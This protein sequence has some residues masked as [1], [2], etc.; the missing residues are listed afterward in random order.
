MNK[1]DFINELQSRINYTQE[2]CI[3]VNDVLE[4]HYVFRKKNKAKITEDLK[5]KLSISEEQ[6]EYV[7]EQ[8]M[9]IIHSQIKKVK[10]HPFGDSSKR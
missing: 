6:A 7:Y 4:A 2:Q 8:A 1:T 9:E 10:R 3:I 5:E